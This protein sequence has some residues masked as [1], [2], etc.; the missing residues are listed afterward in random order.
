[1]FHN[2]CKLYYTFRV[3]AVYWATEALPLAIT[4]LIPIAAFPLMGIEATVSQPWFISNLIQTFK[5]C[6]ETLAY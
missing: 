6:H 4:A 2:A 1:M 5:P 3:A